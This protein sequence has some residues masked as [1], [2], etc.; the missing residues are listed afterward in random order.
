VNRE[1]ALFLLVGV[2]A[3]FL[4]GYLAHEAMTGVQPARLAPGATAAAAP[5]PP[6]APPGGATPGGAGEAPAMAEINR[7]REQLERNPNDRQALL[8][9]ANLNFDIGG[10]ARAQELYERYLELEPDDPDALTDLGIALRS[11]GQS[12]RALELFRR[13]R[14]IRPEHWQSTFNEV[15]VLAF[16][17]EDFRAAEERLAELRRLAPGN[18]DVERLAEEVARRR[19]AA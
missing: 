16:D 19:D 17:L 1:H 2:L 13:A 5:H 6:V 9:L 15:V 3:G 4:A 12:E 8:A 11:Q 10:W 18:A 7:L 14:E